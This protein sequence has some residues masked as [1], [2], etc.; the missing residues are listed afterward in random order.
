M[1]LLIRLTN[2][3]CIYTAGDKRYKIKI[4]SRAYPNGNGQYTCCEICVFTENGWQYVLSY[5]KDYPKHYTDRPFRR[6]TNNPAA[7][8]EEFR[9]EMLQVLTMF[10][11]GE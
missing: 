10:H 8:I 11:D 4:W 1:K 6:F 3:E 7:E 9:Q 2:S 5:E